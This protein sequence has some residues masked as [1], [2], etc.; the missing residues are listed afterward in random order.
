MISPRYVSKAEYVAKAAR[1]G[2]W[3]KHERVLIPTSEV[4]SIDRL[5]DL[6]RR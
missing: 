6:A 2:T 1:V 5:G 4:V 3:K